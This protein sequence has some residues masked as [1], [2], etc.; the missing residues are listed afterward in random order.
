MNSESSEACILP[1]VK[2]E[3]DGKWLC[4]AGAQSG[5]L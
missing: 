2:S 3:A 5:A 1:C 4:N